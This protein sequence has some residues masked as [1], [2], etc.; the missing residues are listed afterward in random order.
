MDTNA[1]ENLCCFKVLSFEKKSFL[2]EFFTYDY[3]FYQRY[4]PNV[5]NPIFVMLKN[6]LNC[7]HLHRMTFL[8]IFG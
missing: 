8:I 5:D 6:S 7:L 4:I 2:T 1:I 3:S